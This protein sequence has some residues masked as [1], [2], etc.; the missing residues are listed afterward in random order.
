M[1]MLRKYSCASAVALAVVSCIAAASDCAV[2]ADAPTFNKDIA[3]IVFSK[4]MSCHREGEVGPFPLTNYEELRRRARQIAMVTQRRIMPPWKPVPGHNE[5]KFDRSLTAEQVAVFQE[6]AKAGAPEG[7]PSDLP[8]QPKFPSGWLLGEPDMI[9]KLAKPFPVH[10]EGKDI[11]VQF[12]FPLELEQDKYIR[13]VQVRPSNSRVAHHGVILLDGSKTARKLAKEHDS[14]RA[15]H[16]LNFGDAGFIP[17]GFL[18]GYAPGHTTAREDV[19]AKEKPE[20]ENEVGLVLGK[21]L[22]VVLQMHYH[23]TGKPEEDQPQIGLYFTDKKPQRGPNIIGMANNDV[24]IAPGEKEFVRTDTFKLPV[25]FEVRDIYAHMHMIGKRVHVQ[26][27]LPGG[28]KKELLLIDDWDFNWQDSYVYKEPFVLP[29]GTEIK[30]EWVWDNTADNPRNP[31]HPPQR[32][33]WGPNSDDEM[34]GLIIGGITV[35]P[36]LAD[37]IMWLS[38]IAHY[39]DVENKAKQAQAKRQKGK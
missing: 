39:L 14:E 12:V 7:D 30:A 19:S 10:A 23:P 28:R 37:G 8:P 5:F 33:Q 25:D 3:P 20:G 26:A 22:D 21:G 32:I 16:Y 9:L 11:Y 4:C 34:S 1:E 13:A 27:E 36:G 15:D 38:V 24:D 29:R 17:R 18:P 6:W 2:A 35:K 31:F